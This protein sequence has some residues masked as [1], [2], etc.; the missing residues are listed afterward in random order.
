MHRSWFY[1]CVALSSIL[2]LTLA[3]GDPMNPNTDWFSKAGY[4]V[5]VH[6]LNGLQNDHEQINSLG[7]ETSWDQC[8]K[9]FDTEKFAD[10]MA[11]AGANYV[12][13]T[14]M[15]ISRYLIAPNA[16]YDRLTGYKP[17]EA[18]ATR[19]LIEDLYQSLNKRHIPLM[20][21]Y[22]GDGPRGDEK[23][24]AG[25]QF[26][27]PVTKE[28]VTKWASV[29]AE[30]GERYGD[31]VKG[32]WVDGSYPFIGYTDETLAIMARGLKAG[33]PKRIVAL[34][35]GVD[36]QVLAYSPV[37]DFTCGEQNSFF[38]MP[39]ERFLKGEQWHLLS[40]M[41]TGWGQPGSKYTKRELTEYVA[42]VNRRGG[43]V[44]IEV[45]LFRDGSIDRSQLEVLKAVRDGHK[46]MLAG[47][48]Y[49]PIPPGNFAYHKQAK[50]LSHDGTRQMPVNSGT[51]FA[52][53]GVDGKPDTFALCGE[54]YAWTFEVDMVDTVPVKR[55][56]VT[57]G[58]GYATQF[59]LRV[60]EDG[61]TWKTVATKADGD[62]KPFEAVIEPTKARYVRVCAMKP[63][64]P[65]QKGSQM[66]VAELV[67]YQ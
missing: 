42:D 14:V 16:T 25:F 50:L 31:K 67:V 23:A 58:S 1:L 56:K 55:I 61:Q 39:A 26:T 47:K 5:F 21:Y 57:F 20:L 32:Y 8:V 28:F 37:E 30:Y 13:F 62:G 36:P 65:D 33:N 63:D 2:S 6:Y 9:E 66:S 15:Q 18:C 12:F 29:A 60:S 10:Q 24:N 43:V 11:E 19:D 46:D 52:R 64:G 41:G 48:T 35:R 7:R 49:P 51:Q 22:T 27:T 59:E 34:N 54:E 53:L 45:M 4:G 40:F 3:H 17:G 38:D 44:S